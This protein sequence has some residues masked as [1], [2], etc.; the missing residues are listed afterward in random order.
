MDVEEARRSDEVVRVPE[1]KPARD[2]E[3]TAG[4]VT[5][6]WWLFLVTGIA[7]FFV[8]L[9][10]LRF[11]TAS[12]AT[13]G[14]LLGVFFLG[15]GFNEF[16]SAAVRPSW[17]WAHVIMGVLF[18]AGA[19]W[20]FIRPIEAFW[21][22][23]SVLGFLLVFKGTLDITASAITKDVNDLWWLGL[24]A[25]ILEIL[26]AFWVSQQFFP[27]RASLILIWVGFVA[28]FRGFSEIATGFQ[29]RRVRKAIS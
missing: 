7:W 4:E 11:Q 8:S 3:E 6:L 2:T 25:G 15:A 28:M 10:V 22:L 16:L 27:A 17:R 14:I 13:V 20:A 24:V 23:A 19:L 9:I 18:V 5:G 26:L 1:G 21:A 12:L 29:L